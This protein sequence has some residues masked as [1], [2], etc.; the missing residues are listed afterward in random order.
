[1]SIL[2]WASRQDQ[3][4]GPRRR[5]RAAAAQHQPARSSDQAHAAMAPAP[6]S[7]SLS[8]S[9]SLSPP[10]F[11]HSFILLCSANIPGFDQADPYYCSVL[12][13]HTL[14]Q[15]AHLH[16][17]RPC[18]SPPPLPTHTHKSAGHDH[19]NHRHTRARRRAARTGH[20]QV[21]DVPRTCCS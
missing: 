3:D 11:I 12:M 7:L 17:T 18:S 15:P 2:K 8:L 20:G 14:S 21:H 13:V 10:S 5:R 16:H 6:T 1:M 19:S 4:A 9:L